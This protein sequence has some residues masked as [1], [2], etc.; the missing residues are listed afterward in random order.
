[1]TDSVFESTGQCL[2][3]SYNVYGVSNQTITLRNNRFHCGSRDV[4]LYCR[5]CYG[6]SVTL[7]QNI[8]EDT[9]F[10]T[11]VDLSLPNVPLIQVTENI[12]VNMSGR[13]LSL[14][15]AANRDPENYSVVISD[16]VFRSVG[17]QL[18]ESVVSVYCISGFSRHVLNVSLTRNEFYFNL[19]ST[20]LLT[21][22]AGLFVTENT[23]LNPD[24]T[25]DYKVRV[26]YQD[27]ATMFAPLNYWN[28][29]TFDE[30]ADRI[31]DHEDDERFAS[32][33]VSPW[34]LDVN[35]TQTASGEHKFFKGP[36]EIGGEVESNITLSST[37]QPYRVTQNIV[38][39]LGR[40]LIIEAGV[41][42]L[43]TDGGI[44]VEG[45]CASEC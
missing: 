1:M 40:S 33:Q 43:F 32:V 22:C 9:N 17:R 20:T 41:T 6:M 38:V 23:F 29:S 5:H 24:A 30:I 37:E 13:A 35:R 21:S 26:Q 10:H 11:A 19:A 16:N 18:L 2:T 14:S 7:H 3:S 36:F 4:Y 42:L 44:T 45:E 12:F 31:Y 15:L 25:H 34:Y 39:P 27:V 8:F 28:A